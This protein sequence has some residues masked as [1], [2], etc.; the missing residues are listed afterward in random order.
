DEKDFYCLELASGGIMRS[1]MTVPTNMFFSM[2]M[3]V[4]AFLQATFR[5]YLVPEKKID[6]AISFVSG[7]D[8]EK[9]AEEVIANM[10]TYLESKT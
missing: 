6:E 4:R 5:V 10:L 2:K 1:F 8:F 9:I 7:F 3:K